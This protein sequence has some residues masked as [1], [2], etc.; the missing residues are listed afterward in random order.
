MS[1][2]INELDPSFRPVAAAFLDEL[3]ERR[4][5]CVLAETMRDYAKQ[6]DVFRKGNSRCDGLKNISLHQARLAIDVVVI[7]ETG[8]RSWDYAKHAKTYRLI[9]D[10][11]KKHNLESG[12][13]YLPLN[14]ATGLGWDPPHHQYKGGV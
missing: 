13:D 9:A 2:D 12:A 5:P 3:R 6:A 1:A 7:D 8:K 11:A 4:V 14:K 10:I